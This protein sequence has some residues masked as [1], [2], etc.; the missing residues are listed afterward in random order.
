M[1][2]LT[3]FGYKVCVSA[4]TSIIRPSPRLAL[5]TLHTSHMVCSCAC[6]CGCEGAGVGTGVGASVGAGVGGDDGTAR[7]S[8]P[9]VSSPRAPSAPVAKGALD[10]APDCGASHPIEGCAIEGCAIE[11]C[12]IEGC[13]PESACE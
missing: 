10:E 8:A 2:Y 4:P 1:P 11:G 5:L 7:G 3:G 13:D 9:R 6:P 12:A